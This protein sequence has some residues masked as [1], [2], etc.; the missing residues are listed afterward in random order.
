MYCIKCGVE[1]PDTEKQ[2]P[3]CH[4]QLILPPDYEAKEQTPLYPPGKYPDREKRRLV[5]QGIILAAF[6]MPM[7]IVLILDYQVGG[8]VTWSGFVIGALMVSYVMIGLPTWFRRPNPVIFVPCS[9]VAI[10]VYLLY[11]DLAI[12]GNWFLSFAFP[13][14]GGV[15]LIVTAVVTL[16]KYVGKG[17]MFIF[18]GGAVALGGFLLLVEYLMAITFPNTGMIWWSLYPMVVLVLLGG[19]LIFLGICAPAR[20]VLERKTFF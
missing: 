10:G 18:G 11:I 1:L 16:L 15:G 2:C 19:V 5:A 20:E 3:L 13:V 17:K 12:H 8:A 4:T 9:F 6:L 14:T 7:L